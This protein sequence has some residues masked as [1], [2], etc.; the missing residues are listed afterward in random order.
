MASLILGQVGSSLGAAAGLAGG[1]LGI[2]LGGRVG[3]ALGGELDGGVLG[4]TSLPAR[5][6]PRLADLSVQTSTYGKMIPV[7]YGT[8]RTAG[9]IIWA[10][11]INE[12]ANTTTQTAGGG[13]GGGKVTQS[14]TTFSYSVT[15]A[16]AVCEGPIDEVLRVWADSAVLNLDTDIVSYRLHKG[17][18]DQLPDP[19]IE[20]HEGVG[21]TP[22]YRGLSY[23]VVEDFPLEDYGNRI[24]NFTFEVKRRALHADLEGEILEDLI[25]AMIMI[26]GSGEFV[27]D[28]TVQSKIAGEVAGAEFVERGKKER[29]NQHNRN[30]KADTLVALDQLGETCKNLEWVAPVVT[31]FGD[32]LDAGAC[33][34]LPGVEYKEGA[35]TQPDSWSSGVF[36]RAT[37]KQIT[38][39]E[40][41]SPVYGGTPNDAGV[42]RYLQELKSRGYKVM[43]YPMFFMDVENKPWRGRVTGSLM[44][45][46]SN[47]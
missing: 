15:L 31:W 11:P 16:I 3:G 34:I 18:E 22:A 21:S 42:V 44:K 4:I 10:L 28:T 36:N 25:T 17:D 26:P 30:D 20:A 33:T 9:N 38:L 6:G 24:P 13:K 45:Q 46:Q 47:S 12:T 32:D 27:Y 41:D 37:A 7:L 2:A 23:V 8:V 19:T 43:F 1:P 5:E 29:I 39:D 35:V 40:N 14:Q